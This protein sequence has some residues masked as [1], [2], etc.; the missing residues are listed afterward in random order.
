MQLQSQLSV[1]FANVENILSHSLTNYPRSWGP[2][3]PAAGGPDMLAR[4]GCLIRRPAR[5]LQ[6]RVLEPGRLPWPRSRSP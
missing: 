5:A 2:L 3:P 4:E 6:H 1:A